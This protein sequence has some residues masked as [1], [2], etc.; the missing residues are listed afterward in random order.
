M[1][2]GTCLSLQTD[3]LLGGPPGRLE[4][5][6]GPRALEHIVDIVGGQ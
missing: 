1:L 3:Q 6:R 5:E 4:G 2:V